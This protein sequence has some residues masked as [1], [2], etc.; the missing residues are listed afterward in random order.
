[1]SLAMKVRAALGAASGAAL[2]FGM[3]GCNQSPQ[4]TTPVKRGPS[5]ASQQWAKISSGFVESYFRAQPFFAAQAG[6]HEYRRPAA[7]SQRTWNSARNC[8]V[9]RCAGAA[10]GGR[11]GA[12][13]AE[14]TLRSGISADR[15]RSGPLLSGE[16]A[17]SVQQSVLVSQQYRSGH[18]FD[19]QLCAA[20][21]AHE[22]VHQV[23][24]RHPE[25]GEQY[26][27][28]PANR[29]CPRPTSNWAFPFSA[30]SPTSTR[31]T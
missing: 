4:S 24:A 9:A 23:R 18:V 3:V 6:R 29:R 12:P 30:D 15:G 22:G 5:Q 14:R 17:L 7:G 28:E 8:P 19:S 21:R 25:N 31:R 20:R 10:R 27:G 11:S 13:G 16:G 26:P 2:L 1:M